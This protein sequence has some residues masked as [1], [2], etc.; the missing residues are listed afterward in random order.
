MPLTAHGERM[1]ERMERE[2]G[3]DG[4]RVLYASENKGKP[5][6]ADIHRGGKRG[7][8]HHRKTTRK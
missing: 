2:Y 8:R 6:F 1:K 3:K 5:G 7:K 4:E